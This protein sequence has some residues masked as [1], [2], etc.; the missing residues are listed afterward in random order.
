MLDETLTEVAEVA[1]VIWELG[2]AERN[3]GNLSLDVTDTDTCPHEVALRK[4]GVPIPHREVAGRTFIV[5]ITGSRFREIAQRPE[6]NVIVARISDEAD[7]Y[8]I[9]SEPTKKNSR[10]TS[11]FV[12][13]LAVHAHLRRSDPA[14]RVVLHTHPDH[15]VALTHLQQ[16]TSGRALTDLLWAMH[17]EMK[18][19]L[20]EGIGVVPYLRPGGDE[21]AE[22]TV[23]EL[24]DHRLV[25][26][27]KHGCI[28]VG[29]DL[30]E[31]FDLVDLADKCARLY[32]LVK[33]AGADPQG[34][35]PEQLEEL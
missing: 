9:L 17:P 10:L 6:E 20:P 7:G 31:A 5:T 15:L 27:E 8:E 18:V 4:V 21:L 13:H 28:A 33:S 34:L 22:A 26:W 16:H 35:T 23:A 29:E 30:F 2:W 24:R 14:K 1:R 32:F 3:A 19:V 25:M 11:E 12:S